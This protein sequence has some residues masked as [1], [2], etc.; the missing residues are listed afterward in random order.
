M[1]LHTRREHAALEH[2]RP[3]HGRPPHRHGT[4]VLFAVGC[5]RLGIIGRI[6]DHGI[7]L[8]SGNVHPELCIINAPLRAELGRREHPANSAATVG[9]TRRRRLEPGPVALGQATVRNIAALLRIRRR[10]LVSD[11]PR[12]LRA[13]QAKVLALD[14]QLEIRVQ[15]LA[16]R[17]TVFSR[18]VHDEQ[19]AWPD[20][21][22]REHP[23]T[24]LGRVVAQRPTGEVNRG[25]TG[26]AQFDPVPSLA[27]LVLQ[28]VAV[29]REDFVDHHLAKVVVGVHVVMPTFRG[30]PVRL[31]R[32]VGHAVVH[33][34]GDRHDAAPS[35]L[36]LNLPRTARHAG[37]RRR[38]LA[39]HQQIGRLKPTN[40]FAE[41][42]AHA[43]E[44]AHCAARRRQD[45]CQRRRHVINDAVLVR[46]RRRGGVHQVG[47]TRCVGDAV[48]RIPRQSRPAK[49]ARRECKCP[50]GTP[51]AQLHRRVAVEPEIIG[52][53]PR[54]L[55]VETDRDLAQQTDIARRRIDR[56]HFRRRLV[57]L[58]TPKLSV[59]HEVAAGQVGV[60]SHDG[61]LVFAIDEKL[62][63][64]VQGERL[65]IA[66]LMTDARKRIVRQISRPPDIEHLLT[67]D[68]DNEP[69]III[70][71][72]V[73]G[74]NLIGICQGEGATK[75]YRGVCVLHVA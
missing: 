72:Q 47:R 28:A 21:H 56:R 67:I 39:V 25:I 35:R 16:K 12:Q 57:R 63:R 58:K 41:K 44:P 68:P 30:E 11:T 18:G 59:H 27:L 71:Q 60:E 50:Q 14:T 32:Q 13:E 37:D 23:L 62:S 9:L 2:G 6:P 31:C 48:V 19:T 38:R 7:R 51:A 55:L 34:P 45:G 15:R 24:R 73:E 66:G 61:N 43:V 5:S 69:V 40:R 42:Q 49:V 29:G 26:V 20:R 54:D 70:H 36:E 3:Y 8:V 1:R 65:E 52:V 17:M 53:H 10:N 46:G 4:D 64:I 33:H 22:A 75:K 74:G